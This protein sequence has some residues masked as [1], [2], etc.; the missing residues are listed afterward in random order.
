MPVDRKPLHGRVAVVTGAARGLGAA[1]AEVLVERGARVALLGREE[2][3]LARV[4]DSLPEGTSACWEA[5]VTDDRGM[6][7]VGAEIRARLGPPS[8]VVANAGVAE[9]GPFTESDPAVW[10]RVVEVNLIGSAITARTFLPDLIDTRGYLLQ[11]ASLASIGAAPMM[12]AYCASK[13]GVESFAHALRAE[14]AHRRVGVGI[15][16]I[17]WTDT[18]MV[19]DADEHAVLRK[20]RGH[21]PAPARKVFPAAYV[22]GRLVAAVE[23]RRASVYVPRWLR[24]TQLV[25]AAMPPVVTWLSRR[26]LPRLAAA[27]PFSATGLLGAGGRADQ[28][29]DRGGPPV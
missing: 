10:R 29:A 7:R 18:D 6:F 20:L 11:V 13:A 23:R 4:R 22:A 17:N 3:T 1:M 8:V 5:D 9:G 26:E 21:M 12:S 14:V 28:A 27:E 25:R 19:R 2:R 16:Y 24:S 15:A